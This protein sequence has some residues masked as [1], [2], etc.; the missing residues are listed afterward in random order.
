M[1]LVK[2]ESV[3]VAAEAQEGIQKFRHARCFW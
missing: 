3:A 2:W 1:L